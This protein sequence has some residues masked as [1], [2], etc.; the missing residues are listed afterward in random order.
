MQEWCYLEAQQLA[1]QGLDYNDAFD[2]ITGQTNFWDWGQY[3][4]SW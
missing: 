2:L 3:F 4:N 1:K